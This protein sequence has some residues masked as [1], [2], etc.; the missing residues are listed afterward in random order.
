MSYGVSPPPI[1]R[2]RCLNANRTS[3]VCSIDS[4]RRA[5]NKKTQLLANRAGKLDYVPMNVTVRESP[6]VNELETVSLNVMP[7][8]PPTFQV[9]EYETTARSRSSISVLVR[10]ED[11]A[12]ERQESSAWI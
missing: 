6:T 7:G 5:W 8:V 3:I 4:Y 9:P 2:V 11:M 1:Y 10:G 12:V